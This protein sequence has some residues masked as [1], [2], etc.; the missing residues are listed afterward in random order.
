[1]GGERWAAPWCPQSTVCAAIKHAA[2]IC[3]SRKLSATHPHPLTMGGLE[4]RIRE[5]RLQESGGQLFVVITATLIWY[6]SSSRNSIASQKLLYCEDGRGTGGGPCSVPAAAAMGLLLTS[7]ELA[8][9]SVFALLA[10][11]RV[12]LRPSVIEGSLHFAG[13]LCTN[14][15][16]ALG[17]ASLVQVV[18]LLEPIETLILT[19]AL[20]AI[21]S[22]RV[23]VSFPEIVSVL[24]VIGGASL[25]LVGRT[26][27]GTA[28][29]WASFAF[30][31]ASGVCMTARNV[32]VKRARGTVGAATAVQL[33]LGV[34]SSATMTCSG[35]S[36]NP[37]VIG[38]LWMSQF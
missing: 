12:C 25:L 27:N 37:S 34:E 3:S 35:E 31:L 21:S 13:T 30:A 14:C 36:G 6:Y 5:S 4:K 9:G 2:V 16:F 8:V 26:G 23:S 29:P 24:T 7:L 33:R 1:M 32:W 18:K 38:Q 20:S 15:G 19:A 28:F 11:G 17:G 22:G 10:R